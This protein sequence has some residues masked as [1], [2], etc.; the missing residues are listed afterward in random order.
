VE[1]RDYAGPQDLRAMQRLVQDAWALTGPKN[2]R[3]VGDVAW[4]AASIAGR[5]P[6]W[7]L[8]LWEDGGRVVAYG[9]LFRP[10]T[11]ERQ[12]DPQRP[13][14][15]HDV[16]DWF[17]GAAEDDPLETSVLADDAAGIEILR[18]RGYEEVADASWFAYMIRALDD[19]P[20]PS[21]PPGYRLR[22]V[23][24]NDVERRVDVHRAAWDPSRFTVESYRDVRATWPYREDLDC[25]AEAA[26]GSFASY[27]LAWYDDENRVGELEPVGTRPDHRRRGLARAVNL[28]ALHRLR[29]VGAERAIVLCRGDAGYPVPKLLYESVG[30]RQHSRS[31]TFRTRRSASSPTRRRPARGRAAQSR[32]RPERPPSARPRG[33]TSP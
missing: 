24:E 8:R 7:R 21:V 22:T 31:V 32:A 33:R 3:H 14:L 19:L 26:D 17:A 9:W 25:V 16:L 23:T 30:F 12:V 1:A 2:E 10:S 5:E 15:V 29:D 6:E 27:A 4:A 28:F 18:A 11:L 13:E 20:D